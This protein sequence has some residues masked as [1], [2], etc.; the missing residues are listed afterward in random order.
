MSERIVKMRSAL[1]SALEAKGTPGTWRHI[2]D[3]IGMFS[4]TGLSTKQVERLMAEFHVYLTKDGRISMAGLNEGNVGLFASHVDT[5]VRETPADPAP[6]PKPAPAK[7][8][9]GPLRSGSMFKNVAVAPADPILGLAAQF[10]EDKDPKKINL[11]IGA[12]RSNAGVP[13]VLPSV[14]TAEES[15]AMDEKLDKE[16]F[17]ID[18]APAYKKPV[19]ELLFPGEVISS[20]RI[21]TCQALS[22]TG[23]LRVVG[24]FMNLNLGTKTVWISDPTWGNH[25]AIFTKS[26]MTCKE[27]PYFHPPTKGFD[28][29]GMMKAIAIM[30]PGDCILLH[31]VAHNPTGVDPTPAQWEALLA[32]VK[33]RKLIP[34]LDNAYQG[35][36]SG[37]LAKDNV[38]VEI[39][40]RLG[41]EFFITQSFAKNFGLYGERIGY[42]HVCCSDKD[43]ADAVL[44]QL[45]LV[46]RPMY[47]S[48]PMH[49][50]HL[51]NRV[52]SNPKLKQQWLDELT[53]MSDRIVKM[54]AAVRSA[55]EAKGTPGKWN[56]ITDQIGM[57]SYTGLTEPQCERLLSEFHIYLLKSGRIS[58]AGI[59]EGNVQRFAECVDKVVRG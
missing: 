20:G 55:L 11:G 5:V 15:I 34:L 8:D 57:F 23:A 38:S 40:L 9:P 46:V 6:A 42:V 56:H 32:A 39:L 59:N 1:R 53:L 49:G 50:A 43:R 52:L 12:Y 2:T 37:S 17:P 19:Q 45:K 29:D 21:A 24:H 36:A 27:Y 33:E 54:R 18:G 14:C 13:W 4:F 3:Q 30:Q 51:V 48:P 25:K 35:Y 10:K 22:G 16:Y 26:G 41:M 7:R 47:S 44:S 31:A 58:M 28:F